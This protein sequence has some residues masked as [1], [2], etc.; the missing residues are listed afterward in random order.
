MTAPELSPSEIARWEAHEDA[1]ESLRERV[2]AE[3]AHED[4]KALL[5]GPMGWERTKATA[6]EGAQY[7]RRLA[8]RAIAVITES[9][10]R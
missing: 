3:L 8:D 7:Y 1:P 9:A 4:Q 10:L 2:A 6:P 5:H